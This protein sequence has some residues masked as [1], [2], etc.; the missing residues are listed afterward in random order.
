MCVD[1]FMFDLRD[2]QTNVL[3]WRMV[4]FIAAFV[5]FIGNLLFVIFSRTEEQPWNDASFNNRQQQPGCE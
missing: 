5:Y 2:A 1:V 3:Q 4:F